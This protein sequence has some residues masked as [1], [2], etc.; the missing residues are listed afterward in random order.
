M[1][2]FGSDFQSVDGF[3]RK[4]E[5]LKEQRSTYYAT[6]RHAFGSLIAYNKWKRIW[7]PD[8]YCYDVV[9]YLINNGFRISF[10][11]TN[12]LNSS[13]DYSNLAFKEGDALLK[14][15][16]FGV[17]KFQDNSVIPIP[18][19]EDHSHD[20]IGEWATESNADYCFASLRKSIPIPEGGILWS[21]TNKV[22]PKKPV[23]SSEIE[24]IVFKRKKA[25]DLKKEYLSGSGDK[26]VYRNIFIK[27]ESELANSSISSI[28]SSTYEF[29]QNFDIVSW[30]ETKRRNWKVSQNIISD[31]I[32]IL[33]PKELSNSYPFS[34]IILAE[35]NYIRE[36]LRKELILSDIYPSILWNIPKNSSNESL[37]LS[38]RI[39]SIPCDA[40]YNET[41]VLE[42][43]TKIESILRKI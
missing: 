2:E 22:L 18:V 14:I 26:D 29:L 40:R 6:G 35:N 39:L 43:C 19:I 27:T 17:D 8:Y 28:S 20:L 38:E 41:E 33:R 3:A 5:K 30:Y 32:Q 25:M 10:Y 34:I 7:I 37:D 23:V 12:P 16:Y 31:K 24:T 42:A 13:F 21:P 9:E 4:S 1:R 15:N 36:R 11:S